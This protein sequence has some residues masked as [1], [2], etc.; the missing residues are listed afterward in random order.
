MDTVGGIYV[1]VCVL[2]T[3]VTTIN[4]KRI[5]IC[6]EIRRTHEVEEGDVI[7]MIMYS[8]YVEILKK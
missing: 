3:Y 5:W 7:E 4:E 8:T 1:C 2:F 6:K